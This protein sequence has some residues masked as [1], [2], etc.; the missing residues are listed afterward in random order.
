MVFHG[1]FVLACWDS[2]VHVVPAVA[3]LA[4]KGQFKSDVTLEVSVVAGCGCE[5]IFKFDAKGEMVDSDSGDDCCGV[6]EKVVGGIKGWHPPDAC[7][8]DDNL[9]PK[10]AQEFINKF[11]R[12][13][14]QEVPMS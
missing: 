9:M 13:S 6:E 7:E 8:A 3:R 14:K 1:P 5:E 12:I 10:A 2:S 4:M 11:L